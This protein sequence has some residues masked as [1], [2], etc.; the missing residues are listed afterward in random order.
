MGR[1]PCLWWPDCIL[2]LRVDVDRGGV[3]NVR[4]DNTRSQSR[5]R[6]EGALATSRADVATCMRQGCLYK[7]LHYIV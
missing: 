7:D 4:Q 5:R 2:K 3:K 1:T 6:L